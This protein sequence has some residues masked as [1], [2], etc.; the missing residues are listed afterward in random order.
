MVVD[1]SRVGNNILAIL[2]VFG[3]GY[4]VYLKSRGDELFGKLRGRFGGRF[5]REQNIFKR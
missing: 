2:I 4:M 5:G 3:L 1:L